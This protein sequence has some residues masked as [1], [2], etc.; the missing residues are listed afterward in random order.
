MKLLMFIIR[1]NMIQKDG[2]IITKE[3]G[4]KMTKEDKIQFILRTLESSSKKYIEHP[5]LFNRNVVNK[6]QFESMVIT[7]RRIYL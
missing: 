2:F 6:G 4:I 7:G 1:F 3:R 5:D